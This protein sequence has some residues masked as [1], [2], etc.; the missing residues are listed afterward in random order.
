MTVHLPSFGMVQ[1]GTPRGQILAIDLRRPV[2]SSIVVASSAH[3][4]QILPSGHQ[5]AE[6]IAAA[7]DRPV[8]L[9]RDCRLGN[10]LRYGTV[11]TRLDFRCFLRR[12][13]LP[14]RR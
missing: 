9:E 12:G 7:G 13:V 1:T 11:L 6:E 3:G 5:R 10:A 4:H 14:L 2:D 8:V